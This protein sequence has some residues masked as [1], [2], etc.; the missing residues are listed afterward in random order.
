MKR[1]LILFIYLFGTAAWGADIESV[2]HLKTPGNPAESYSLSWKESGKNR[3]RLMSDEVD[4]VDISVRKRDDRYLFSVAAKRQ[5]HFNLQNYLKTGMDYEQS[6]FLM[7]GLWYKK[8]V[9]S[10]DNSPK[11]GEGDSWSFRE[12]R[13]STPLTGVYDRSGGKTLTILRTD[14][15]RTDA[16]ALPGEGEMIL[17][18]HSDLGS[19]GFGRDAQGVYLQFGYP[20]VETPKTY[21]RKLTLAP[22]S[23]TFLTMEKGQKLSLGYEIKE[24]R[25]DNFSDFVRST[26][27]YSYD[28]LKPEPL[29]STLPTDEVKQILSRFYTQSYIGDHELKGFSGI[30]ILTDKAEK[31]PIFEVGFIG[32]VLLNAFNALEYGVSTDNDELEEIARSVFDSY[33][34]HG[35]DGNGFIREYVDYEHGESSEERSIRRQSEGVYAALLYLQYEKNHGRFYPE[36]E[37]RL[38]ALLDNF[39]SLQ[40][41]DG[42]FPRKFSSDKTII[43]ESGGS[44]AS[45]VLSLVMA[46]RYFDD[47]RYLTSAQQAAS[48]LADVIVENADYFSSTLDANSVDKE[49]SFYTATAFYYLALVS[50][51]EQRERYTDLAEKANYFVMSWY[52]TWDVPFAKGQM[53]GDV[54]F[55]TRGWGNV[56]VENN[57]V[58]VFIFGYLDVLRWLSDTRDSPRL[59]DFAAVIESSMKSQ[60][61]PREGHM[62]NIAKVGYHPEVV[63]H[64]NWDYGHFGKGFYNDLFAP[65]WVVP[66]LWEML[67]DDRARAFL[68]DN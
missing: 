41:D 53:L 68:S 59:R 10:S 19:L 1:L 66:S 44:S 31:R 12:D 52:Y 30:H 40:R 15:H 11:L 36:W 14:R 62:V 7:P 64:T 38:T 37:E 23:L 9:R 46:Y 57:H 33:L 65:G 67:S 61:L 58:D 45:A 56:S 60:L 6:D 50:E 29:K 49:A 22:A 55:K 54:G 39:V 13:L 25:A 16:I 8:N 47:D 32:R 63:Q 42:S 35:F 34:E 51:G 17:S 20:Y 48:Y 24:D 3:W 2:L 4:G 5:I 27:E 26:W 28:S 18:G 43:D 21:L